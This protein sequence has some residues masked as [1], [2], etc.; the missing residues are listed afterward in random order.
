[1]AKT[2]LIVDDEQNIVI[3][4]EFLLERHGYN[5]HIAYSGEEALESIINHK[6][7]LILLDIMLPGIDGFEVCEIVRLKP[8][9]KDIKIIFLTA[10]GRDVDIVKGMVLGADIYITKPFSNKEVIENIDMLLGAEA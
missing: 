10:K 3:P 9:W 2:I 7:D 8:E 4:L 6:P 1:M 5:V